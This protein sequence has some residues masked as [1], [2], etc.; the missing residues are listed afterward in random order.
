[1]TEKHS[2]RISLDTIGRQWG[3]IVT[4]GFGG[5]RQASLAARPVAAA[6]PLHKTSVANALPTQP[7]AWRAR[8]APKSLLAGSSAHFVCM[9]KLGYPQ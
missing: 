9:C 7:K 1:M 4:I 8:I 6:S 5:E 3:R 2:E